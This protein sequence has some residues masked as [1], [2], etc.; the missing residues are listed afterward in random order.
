MKKRVKA[1]SKNA[2]KSKTETK[3]QQPKRKT[4]LR[5]IITA[6]AA[7][8]FVALSFFVSPWFILLAV[9]LWWIN[10]KAIRNHFGN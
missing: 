6:L 8:G 2:V 4:N 7:L 9:L 5:I 3:K 10:K 1:Q